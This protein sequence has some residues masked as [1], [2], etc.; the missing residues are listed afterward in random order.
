M[1]IFD[2]NQLG[3]AERTGL[4]RALPC[5]P[6]T[7]PSFQS[8]RQPPHTSE[9]Q[10]NPALPGPFPS[11]H[12]PHCHCHCWR[13]SPLRL[14]SPPPAPQHIIASILQTWCGISVL[15]LVRPSPAPTPPRLGVSYLELTEVIFCLGPSI[16][17]Q[18]QCRS[19][20]FSEDLTSGGLK[21]QG[22]QHC[23]R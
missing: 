9:M 22:S 18:P 5:P 8:S 20:S 17:P 12:S 1:A 19:P 4:S 6:W 13:S 15:V 16:A 7:R 23:P 14:H 11:S 21:A 10:V 3:A 2:R